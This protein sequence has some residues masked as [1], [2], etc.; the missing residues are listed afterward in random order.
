MEG[1]VIIDNTVLIKILLDGSSSLFPYCTQR[2]VINTATGVEA[3][4]VITP[5]NISFETNILNIKLVKTGAIINL[6]AATT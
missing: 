6:A 1:I 3:K 5:T 4:M 2:G